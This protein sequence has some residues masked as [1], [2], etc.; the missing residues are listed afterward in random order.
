MINLM[1]C[2]NDKVFDGI[3]ITLLSIIKHTKETLNVYL[4]TMDLSD[5]NEKFVPITEEHRAIIENKLKEKNN[6]NKVTLIDETEI[7][8]NEMIKN[9]NRRTHY[10]PYIFLRLLSDKIESLPEKILYLDTD[11]VC[12]KDIKELY[13]IDMTNYEIAA[14][15]DFIG[16]KWINQNYLNS[17]VLLMN[18]NNIRKSNSFESC[19][20]MCMTRRMVLPDQTALNKCCK[21]KLILENKF[22]EQYKRE[23]ETVLRHFSM[24]LLYFPIIRL[25]NIKPWQIDKVHKVL[26]IFDYDDIYEDFL[27]VKEEVYLF[28]KQQNKGELTNEY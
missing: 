3:L 18:L 5:I 4:M 24:Q 2:G 7:Y 22:N 28:N 11:I 9:I 26:K 25:R 10:T 27:K 21:S 12:Y 16:K 23:T 8:K 19:R 20:K 13:N 17:G 6:E 1:M 15:R 14:A